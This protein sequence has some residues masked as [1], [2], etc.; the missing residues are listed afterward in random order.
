MKC[1]W[2]VQSSVHTFATDAVDASGAIEQ[3]RAECIANNVEPDSYAKA[4][5]ATASDYRTL[6]GMVA[7]TFSERLWFAV[8][9]EGIEPISA[10]SKDDA[11]RI[12]VERYGGT[13]DDYRPGNGEWVIRTAN[14]EDWWG[15]VNRADEAE[16]ALAALKSRL[17]D[18]AEEG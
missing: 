1:L 4:R 7:D 17:S 11:R 18:I 6:R 9:D 2:L 5:L 16:T 10:I 15:Y 8:S 14:E 12:M 3:Y 13:I